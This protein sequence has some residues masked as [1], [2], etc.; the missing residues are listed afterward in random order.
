[1]Q[2]TIHLIT[3]WVTFTTTA[4]NSQPFQPNYAIP[5]KG[6]IPLLRGMQHA[7]PL[8]CMYWRWNHVPYNLLEDEDFAFPSDT[9]LSMKKGKLPIVQIYDSQYE[10][11]WIQ[12]P[13]SYINQLSGDN[14]KENIFL[15][16]N[17]DLALEK[18]RRTVHFWVNPVFSS[19]KWI[20]PCLMIKKIWYLWFYAHD[21]NHIP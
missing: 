21:Y 8:Y 1:M 2:L 20:L 10:T 15:V 5:R 4:I 13:S 17:L 16:L 7:S 6:I 3:L 11:N 18:W 12:T 14:D 9:F 19:W